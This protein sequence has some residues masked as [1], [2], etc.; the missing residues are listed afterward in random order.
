MYRD[1]RIRLLKAY[2]KIIYPQVVAPCRAIL[3]GVTTKM[4]RDINSATR[5]TLY[6]TFMAIHSTFSISG[7]SPP[8]GP[9][10][11]GRSLQLKPDIIGILKAANSISVC[12]PCEF[13]REG[14]GGCGCIKGNLRHGFRES[15]TIQIGKHVISMWLRKKRN[16]KTFLTNFWDRIFWGET[17]TCEMICF[18]FARWTPC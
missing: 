4:T 13:F 2:D 7:C 18:F 11:V 8:V 12:W 6:L 5:E 14:G 10:L 16:F 9:V 17:S 15:E 1:S 3:V